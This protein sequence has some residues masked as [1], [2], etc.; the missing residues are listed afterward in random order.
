MEKM[1]YNSSVCSRWED[2]H[3]GRFLDIKYSW[4]HEPF[5]PFFFRLL[6]LRAAVSFTHAA[7]TRRDSPELTSYFN[8]PSDVSK[9][10]DY[11]KACALCT[12]Y[13]FLLPTVKKMEIKIKR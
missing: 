6:T 12:L 11:I 7:L 8:F 4:K 9:E 3:T 2:S 5:S 13:V 10:N 1:I